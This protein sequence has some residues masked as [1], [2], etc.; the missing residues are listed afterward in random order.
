[1]VRLFS[2][3]IKVEGDTQSSVIKWD[4]EIG[5]FSVDLLMQTLTNQFKWSPSHM[6]CV[7]FFDK[8]MC[9]DVC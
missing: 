8:M 1:M 7:W 2:L 5:A 4:V 6:P 9:E 3:E